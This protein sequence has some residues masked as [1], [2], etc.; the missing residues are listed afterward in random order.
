METELGKRPYI[1]A[2]L[3]AVFGPWIGCF[4]LG[5]G[6]IGLAYLALFLILAPMATGLLS[7]V[8]WLIGAAHCFY[9]AREQGPT[10]RPWYSRGAP[11]SAIIVAPLALLALRLLVFDLNSMPAKSMSPNIN[12]G[13]HVIVSRLAYRF[14]N[15]PQ[16]GDVVTFRHGG[17]VFL[18]RIVGLPG[19]TVQYKDG[20]LYLNGE[21]QARVQ[22]EDTLLEG[23]GLEG[24]PGFVETVGGGRSYFILERTNDAHYDNTRAY[25]VQEGSYFMLGDNRDESTDSRTPSFGAV[26][27]DDLI[28][29]ALL[30]YRSFGFRSLEESAGEDAR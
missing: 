11:L 29:K 27:H 30:V 14:G 10:P 2:L 23:R 7:L 18:K 28:G 12:A 5:R 15:A 25:K 17:T 6:W 22:I 16:R 1:A 24:Y 4:Y 13:D 21:R 19:D 9:L 20:Q 3:A 8:P 26:S